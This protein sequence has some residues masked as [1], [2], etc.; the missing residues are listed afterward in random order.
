M[1]TRAV[2]YAEAAPITDPRRQQEA[3]KRLVF[4]L[5]HFGFDVQIKPA[6]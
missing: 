2:P 5:K 1:L 4:R 6:T 3:A